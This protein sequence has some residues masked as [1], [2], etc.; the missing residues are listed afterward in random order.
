MPARRTTTP[1]EA[2][3][4]ARSQ[5]PAFTG[6]E[7]H[8]HGPKVALPRLACR[9]VRLAVAVCLALAL[10][11]AA[12]AHGGGP[13]LPDAVAALES[14]QIYVDYDAKPTL[15]EL[16]ADALG[17]KLAEKAGVYVAVLPVSVTEETGVDPA[18][19]AELLADKVG[20]PGLY[21]VS[22]GGSVV[23]SRDSTLHRLRGGNLADQLTKLVQ[24]AAPA[25]TPEA[26]GRSW[27]R[28][29]LIGA[30]VL[31]ATGAALVTASARLRRSRRAI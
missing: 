14:G 23:T 4:H 9:A 17:R 15:T 8:E 11:C 29:A 2:S 22:V 30:V 21:V 18:R 5:P 25:P 10:P 16:E 28:D 12:F 1:A 6:C 7:Q 19:L 27:R 20:R 24:V 31:L 3:E 26:E 13:V